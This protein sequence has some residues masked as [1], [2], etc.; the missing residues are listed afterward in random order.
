MVNVLVMPF[1]YIAPVRLGAVEIRILNL[2]DL[3]DLPRSP[4]FWMHPQNLSNQGNKTQAL[5]LISRHNAEI[6]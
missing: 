3:S 2:D 5:L 4:A 1:L 6:T